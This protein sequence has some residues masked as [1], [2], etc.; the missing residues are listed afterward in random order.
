VYAAPQNSALPVKA[1]VDR[2]APA[3]SSGAPADGGYAVTVGFYTSGTRVGSATYAH[4][5]PTV[6]VGMTISRRG[7]K[8]GTVG[9][10]RYNTCWQGPH[11]HFQ[12]YS[13]HNYACYSRTWQPRNWV[14]PSNFLGFTGGNVAS[15][16]VE[17]APEAN[18]SRSPGHQLGLLDS[19]RAP[20]HS[21]LGYPGRGT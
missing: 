21:C 6:S 4:I 20:D 1:I 13:E 11:L 19:C 9:S 14:N 2:V 18:W 5:N 17:P 7:T 3:C 8:V 16:P 15:G 10:Y 12:L